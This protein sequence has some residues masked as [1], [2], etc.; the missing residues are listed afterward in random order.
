MKINRRAFLRQSSGLAGLIPFLPLLVQQVQA[1]SVQPQKNKTRT[2]KAG[3]CTKCSCQSYVQTNSDT[4]G[5][6]WFG[7][8]NCICDHSYNDHS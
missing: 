3:H 7:A 5:G 1:M 2:M 6:D 4:L 8:G